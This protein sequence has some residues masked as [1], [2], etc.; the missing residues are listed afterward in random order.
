MLHHGASFS[1]ANK[2]QNKVPKNSLVKGEFSFCLNGTA[3]YSTAVLLLLFF[4][5]FSAT[6]MGEVDLVTQLSSNYH[7]WLSAIQLQHYFSLHYPLLSWK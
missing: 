2:R 6:I 7:L 4:F 1:E 3:L 5:Q